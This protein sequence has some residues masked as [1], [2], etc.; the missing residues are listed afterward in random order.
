[1][2]NLLIDEQPIMVLPNLATNIGL[3]EAIVLQQ[4]HY[5]IGRTNNVR[6]GNKWIYNSYQ[7]WNKQF[8]FW[9]LA[10]LKRTLTSLKKNRDC[11]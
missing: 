8:P 2:S 1:M 4:I 5:W 3:N 6:D 10:T 9:S 11:L 7:N